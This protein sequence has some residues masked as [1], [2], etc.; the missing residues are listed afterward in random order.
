MDYKTGEII[1]G[2]PRINFKS[3]HLNLLSIPLRSPTRQIPMLQQFPLMILNPTWTLHLRVQSLMTPPGP[4]TIPS[5]LLKIISMM[6]SM[7]R[8]SYNQSELVLKLTSSLIPRHISNHGPTINHD[9]LKSTPFAWSTMLLVVMP[10]PPST[11]LPSKILSLLP[12]CML[13]SLISLFRKMTTGGVKS[14]LY[15]RQRELISLP[16][17]GPPRKSMI[18]METLSEPSPVFVLMVSDRFLM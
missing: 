2:L 8:Y 12:P 11:T 14:L 1:I 4:L 16:T 7:N 6:F 17:L 9:A 13:K 3:L 18:P 10:F 5:S 15:G